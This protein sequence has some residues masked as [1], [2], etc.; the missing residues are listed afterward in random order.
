MHWTMQANEH[1]CV[2]LN[3]RIICGPLPSLWLNAAW[4]LAKE[5]TLIEAMQ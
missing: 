1:H 5:L 2:P 3:G 4:S